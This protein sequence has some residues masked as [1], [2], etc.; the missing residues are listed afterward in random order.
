MPG[1]QIRRMHSAAMQA[2]LSLSDEGAGGSLLLLFGAQGIAGID[3]SCAA[4][5][6]EAGEE[7]SQS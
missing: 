1:L 3:G 7:R 5:G 6:Q 2:A 4:R